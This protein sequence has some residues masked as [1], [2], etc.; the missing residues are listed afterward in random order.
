M[1][2]KLIPG[3]YGKIPALG[4]FSSKR[5]PS[6]FIRLWDTWLQD[7][8]VTSRSQLGENWLEL[9]LNCPIWRFMLLPNLCDNCLWT[10]ILMPSVDKIGRYFPLTFALKLEPRPGL[11]LAILNA[12]NWYIGLEK[13]ALQ[14]LDSKMSL[15]DLDH[16]LKQHSFPEYKK[17]FSEPSIQKFLLNWNKDPPSDFVLHESAKLSAIR[18]FSTL[19]SII[20]EDTFIKTNLS[21]SIWW[22]ESLEPGEL[23]FHCFSG[24]PSTSQFSK[25]MSGKK[26]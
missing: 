17:N 26:S 19:I 24:L 22:N 14:S 5:L 2:Q 13:L 12:Q 8:M 9:Y 3:W 10:G 16:N 18:D 21:K 15:G 7:S 20:M 1:D 25:L 11:T 23:H 4:D 6:D